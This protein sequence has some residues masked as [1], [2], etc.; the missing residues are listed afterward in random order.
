MNAKRSPGTRIV[1]FHGGELRYQE[2]IPDRGPVREDLDEL[3]AHNVKFV[4]I[5]VMSDT[6]IWMGLDLADGSHVRCHFSPRG[7]RAHIKYQA[8]IEKASP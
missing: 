6:L 4:H 3:V 7:K 8:E 2:T 5:E 1:P